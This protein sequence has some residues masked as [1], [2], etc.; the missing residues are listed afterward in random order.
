MFQV[1]ILTCM[2]RKHQHIFT[3]MQFIMIIN[4]EG[5]KEL[6]SCN[7]CQGHIVR[8]TINIHSEKRSRTIK[9]T[10]LDYL[11][12]VDGVQTPNAMSSGIEDWYSFAHRW[13]ATIN[14]STNRSLSFIR[15]PHVRLRPNHGIHNVHSYRF[16]VTDP[17]PFHNSIK[18]LVEGTQAHNYTKLKPFNYNE[19]YNRK[20]KKQYGKSHLIFYYAKHNANNI[21]TDFLY[22]S[23]KTSES[24]HDYK[25]TKT[26]SKCN[27]ECNSIFHV[28]NTYF[29]YN[30]N[31]D[32]VSKASGRI[33][34]PN[35]AIEFTLQ[36][37]VKH[38]SLILRRT[39]YQ[40]P[41]EWNTKAKLW[42]NG[43]FQGTWLNVKGSV[44]EKHS[45]M[46]DNYIL[47]NNIGKSHPGRINVKLLT[48]TYWRDISYSIRAVN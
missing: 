34:C 22:V 15:I 33:I 11:V 23:N 32:P 39:S 9:N 13:K 4:L 19:Y 37:K 45:L 3:C 24:L 18:L 28:T 7:N 43:V 14:S 26:S 16:H 41:V 21:E 46:D 6:F 1:K 31:D 27:R 35:T 12:H 44:T 48:M 42:V 29:T 8:L 36:T 20:S 5:Y 2:K 38:K 30:Q 25:V 10:E 47:D 17:I 40:K